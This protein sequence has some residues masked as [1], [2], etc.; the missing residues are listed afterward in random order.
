[1]KTGTQAE[2]ACAC[3][4]LPGTAATLTALPTG[5]TK[6][7]QGHPSPGLTTGVSQSQRLT[8]SQ[9]AAQA[10]TLY[11]TVIKEKPEAFKSF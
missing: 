7:G 2:Q 4:A 9:P 8:P 11:R 6:A 1:M 3:R 5:T 10:H